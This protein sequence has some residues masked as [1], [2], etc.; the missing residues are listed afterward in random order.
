MRLWLSNL[1]ALHDHL[2]SSFPEGFVA[3]VLWCEDDEDIEGAILLHYY[4]KRG[5][6]LVPLV[7]GLVKEV[8]RY[9]FDIEIQM[10][11]MQ[12]QDENDAKFTTCS[13]S[14]SDSSLQ[15]KL[16]CKH[17]KKP[18]DGD[19]DCSG[20]NTSTKELLCDKEHKQ[21]DSDC[22]LNPEDPNISIHSFHEESPLSKNRCPFEHMTTVLKQQNKEVSNGRKVRFKSG[23]ES[24]FF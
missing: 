16:G 17:H 13:I 14:A 9:H 4:S 21:I 2:Q 3:P 15:W 18:I 6:L 11:R 22:I 19:D 23:L 1:N 12:M 24:F 20:V 10:T 8:A 7:V 5:S